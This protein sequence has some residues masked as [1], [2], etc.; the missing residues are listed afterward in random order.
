[1]YLRRR[2]AT[3]GLVVACV[4]IIVTLGLGAFF[5]MKIMGGGREVANSSDAGALNVA[6]NV[7]VKVGVQP[8]DEFKACADVPGADITLVT[9]NRCVAQ[10]LLVALNAEKEGTPES[11]RNAQGVIAK[12]KTLGE[13]LRTDI[14]KRENIQPYFDALTAANNTRMNGNNRID[15]SDYQAAFMKPGGASNV[16]LDSNSL[17]IATLPSVWMSSGTI[18]GPNG[19]K[20]LAGYVG[21]PVA[22]QQIYAVPV[23]PQQT[24]HLI[25]LV[26]FL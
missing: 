21:M 9:Y 19:E 6:K 13:Q 14:Q 11:R 18:K 23:F 4:L 1:M 3:L 24:S 22:G 17:P 16:Y 10:A 26:E 2:G 5:L 8:P 12:L 20:F 15:L 25:S 7:L